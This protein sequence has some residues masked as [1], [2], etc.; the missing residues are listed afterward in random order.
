MLGALSR[1]S[2][3]KTPA[4]FSATAGSTWDMRAANDHPSDLPSGNASERLNSWKEIAG[5][6]GRTVRTLQRW[7]RDAGLRIDHFLLSPVLRPRL[8][9]G[10][11][12][13]YVRGMEAPSDHAP[14]WINLSLR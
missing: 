7:E 1:Q 9:D 4:T 12:D 5:Y 14:A 11:V 8:L 6:L 2:R 10:G 13:K 3:T